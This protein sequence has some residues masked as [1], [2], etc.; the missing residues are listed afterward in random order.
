MPLER[1]IPFRKH[2]VS[3]LCE[4][5]IVQER[6]LFR[7]FSTLLVNRIHYQY[8]E[9]LEGLKDSYNDFDPN[10]DTRD[11]TPSSEATRKQSQKAFSSAFANLLN[12][13]NFEKVTNEDLEA[14]L[15]EES[16]FK[17]RLAVSFEDF[18]DVV[19]YRRGES[20]K[21]ETLRTFFGLRKKQVSFT[22][23]DKVA[24]YITFKDEAYFKEKGQTPVTFK[25]GSTIVKL[26]QDVPKADLEMLFPNSEVKMRPLDKLII[27]ASAAIGGTVVLV[28]K[29]GAS[30]LLMASFLA[31]WLGFKSEEVE[32]TK[33]S[34]ITFGIGMGVFGSF[35]FK[36]W[37]KFKNRK[38]RF[39]KALS[40][41]LYFKN[42]DNNAGVFHTLID[43]AEE[44]DCK[45]ALL[46]YTFLLK[47]SEVS[48]EGGA[49]FC[50]V[51]A[52]REIAAGGMTLATLD[53]VIESYFS[54]EL[55]CALDFDVT[56]A[57]SKLV[58]MELVEQYGD[59][60]VARALNDAVK[61]L[62]DYWDN[63]Y[64]PV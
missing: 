38:I 26:F 45:E 58:D 25:P 34:L 48:V 14:A 24:V 51:R 37:T 40:D 20:V 5:V 53:S 31:F 13:A 27:S 30:L 1:F 2:D 50:A 29:L 62:D 23:Y 47:C 44:E 59:I 35:I 52:E 9:Q 19:F 6:T 42:L 64:Q 22:N 60:F 10:K 32:L 17:V 16:L 63:I 54:E 46:A 18:E 28:T 41:N 57:I 7:T 12:A 49:A 39:M 3:R 4:N 55:D 43:A 61:I 21:T 8:H 15:N 11:L 36:E 33:Q 56:D